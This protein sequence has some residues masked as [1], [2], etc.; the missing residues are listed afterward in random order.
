MSKL[1]V[2][3][4]PWHVAHQYSLLQLDFDWHYL[5]QHTRKWDNRARPLPEKVKW[6]THF[7]EGK[8]DL[9]ILHVDQ[10]CL[11]PRLGK[12]ILFKELYNQVKGKVPV[13]VVN[14]GTTVYPENFTQQAA[15]EGYR[16]T[17]EAGE[18]WAKHKMKK[19]LEGVDAMVV[20]S[21]KAREMWGW[22]KTIIHGMDPKNWWNLKKE[23]R[24]V[25]FISP[26]GM[27]EKYYG[28]RLFRET[29]ETLKEKYG[30]SLVW[31]GQDFRATSW[32]EYRDFLGKS[33]VY[34]NP[35]LG[36]P[37]PRTR[38]EAMLSGCAIVTTPNQDAD[39]FIKDGEN[40][41]LCKNNPVDA[42]SKIA[43]LIFNY[44][45]AVL[46]G[47]RGRRTAVRLFNIERFKKEWLDLISEVL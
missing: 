42:A 3:S 27:G 37:M 18:E 45:K 24:V 19:M 20:N 8:Y 12:T 44:K 7:E 10:Q 38:T 25:T 15:K 29:R 39:M 40:G 35:T 21:H 28:R 1:K 14:H 30:I 34:F 33:L 4:V 23:P 36:S 32:D 17:E 43:D 13:I 2:F 22:G 47:E 5:I 41:I 9:A 16:Q 6:V 26:A 31:I 11:L 46:I